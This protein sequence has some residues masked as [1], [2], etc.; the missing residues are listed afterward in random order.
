MMTNA[1][2]NAVML[3]HKVV[4][5]AAVQTIH[6]AGGKV[7]TWTVDDAAQLRRLQKLGVDGIASNYPD[8][9]ATLV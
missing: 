6:R 7:F 9:F 8:L 5:R 4:S 1:R 3:Y 2:A